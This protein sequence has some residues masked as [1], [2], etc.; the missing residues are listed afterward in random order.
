MTHSRSTPPRSADNRQHPINQSLV[1][2]AA[3][4]RQSLR[5]M[6]GLA[7]V[8]IGAHALAILLLTW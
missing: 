1:R 6:M 7:A 8:I 4:R 3:I 5:L 2:L